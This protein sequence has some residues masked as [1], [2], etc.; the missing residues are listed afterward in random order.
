MSEELMICDCATAECENIQGT[1][2]DQVIPHNCDSYCADLFCYLKH[3]DT[4]CIPV[5]PHH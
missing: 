1:Y 2:C 4:K 5:E 3:K